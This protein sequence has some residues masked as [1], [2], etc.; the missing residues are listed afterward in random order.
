[1]VTLT[2]AQT[3]SHKHAK[4]FYKFNVVIVC[5]IYTVV[6]FNTFERRTHFAPETF[7]L[8]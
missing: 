8:C 5:D 4:S 6:Y 1:M 2:S 7:Y 3:R